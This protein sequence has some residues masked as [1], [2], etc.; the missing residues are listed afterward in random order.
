MSRRDNLVAVGSDPDS[1]AT[2]EPSSTAAPEHEELRVEEMWEDEPAPRR[3][4]WIV[5][6]LAIL[7]VLGWTGFFGWAH[8]REMLG[9]G[10]PQEWSDWIVAWSAPVLLVVALWLLAMRNSRREASRFADAA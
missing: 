9:G 7:A 4:G 10:T 1:A 8:Q 3:F 2:A 6:T 5:P